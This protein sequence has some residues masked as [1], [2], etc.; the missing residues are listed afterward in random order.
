MKSHAVPLAPHRLS[1]A[2]LALGVTG[3]SALSAVAGLALAD[4]ARAAV[5]IPPGV[6]VVDEAQVL[7][8]AQ[9]NEI[10]Q[11]IDDLRRSEGQ[12][13]Y[14]LYVD[15]FGDAASS[16]EFI[17]E[18]AQD[19]GIGD[20]ESILAIAVESRQVGF[21]AHQ[22]NSIA[23]LQQEISAE[24]ILP[25]MPAPGD[26]DWVTPA[27]SAV[28]GI[29]DATDGSLSGSAE[30]GESGSGGAGG[31][32]AGGLVAAALAGG[33]IALAS[34]TRKKKSA[35]VRPARGA[36]GPRD[37]LD[38]M[39][40]EALRTKAGS[41]LVAADDAIRSSEQE[42]GFALASYG[43]ESVETFRKD[44]EIAKDHMRESFQLQ[45]QL[46]DHIPDTEEQ[47]RAWLKDIIARCEAVGASLSAH[48][49]E[50]NDL[51]H[52]EDSA[53]SALEDLR[54][55]ADQVAETV[56]GAEQQL[57]EL[58]GQYADSALVEVTDNATQARERLQFV[59]AAVS[60]AEQ[61]LAT[62]DRSTAVLAIRA[63]E[64]AVAQTVT[65]VEAVA[66]ARQHLDQSMENLQVGVSQTTQ[67]LAQARALVD[68]GQ[69]RELAGP[70][71]GVEQTLGL[72]KAGFS[73]GRPDPVD[74]LK[75]L[76]KAHRQLDAPLAGIRDRQEQERR[77]ASALQ[78]AIM[79]AQAQI[80]GTQ[81]FIAARRG[82]VGSQ[83]RTK[84]A[85]AERTLQ[86]A[87]RTSGQDPVTA[88]NLANQASSL[89]DRAS[90]LAQQDLS[91]W[92]GGYAGAGYGHGGHRGGYGHGGGAGGSFAGGLG[93][94]ILGGILM[95]G[96]FGGDHDGGG[97]WGGG[98]FGGFGGGGLG[99]GDFGGGGFGDASGGSF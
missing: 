19:K 48:Q 57:V 84:V 42:V 89:A 52:L 64:E 46:D 76:E 79:Q 9:E 7:T 13:L 27:L 62:S 55:R 91:S 39:S 3:A 75:Q 94:A 65:L 36:Q 50:F 95:G 16:G 88:L 97:D 1:P 10:S 12:G 2:V 86:Q 43:E 30:S 66:K 90:Q 68:S 23:P 69:H 33:G 28:E 60:K 82:A 78:S 67:D 22:A 4:A 14:V 99:G 98:G 74:L 41:L 8:P 59:Q 53:D 81:D 38:E 20:Q 63:G 73:S 72:V 70:I 34:R 37:P 26:D 47:Q 92:G 51:R 56:S 31:W 80:D 93:G 61:S 96:L 87:V 15:D 45:N 6:F 83:A 5:D 77:A 24:Y 40:V 17:A 21:D 32:L 85:E 71:A 18:V 35:E 11:A 58:H 44:I 25:A 29:A 49:K 54:A